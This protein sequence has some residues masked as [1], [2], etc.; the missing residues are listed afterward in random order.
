M[1]K[2]RKQSDCRIEN[3]R[4][5]TGCSR[6]AMWLALLCCPNPFQRRPSCCAV[7]SQLSAVSPFR[8]GL[9]CRGSPLQVHT[10]SSGR[11]SPYVRLMN[12]SAQRPGHGSQLEAILQDH[13]SSR[14]PG[15]VGQGC[16]QP[17]LLHA[18]LCP[19]QLCSP[20]SHRG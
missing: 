13:S 10:L 6:K 12:E 20:P 19:P 11:R 1:R 7:G 3:N 5:D 18:S 15:V 17:S 2:Q 8:G 16:A 9:C 4:T 14:A